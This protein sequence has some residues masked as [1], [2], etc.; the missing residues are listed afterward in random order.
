MATDTLGRGQVLS[1]PRVRV[2]DGE[3]VGTGGT[4]QCLYEDIVRESVEEFKSFNEP[5]IKTEQNL[6]QVRY[7]SKSVTVR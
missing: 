6:L 1:F 7:N 2:L 5:F 3:D 4:V